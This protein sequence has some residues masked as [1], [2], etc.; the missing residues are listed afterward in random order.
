METV[1]RLI[2]LS[3]SPLIDFVIKGTLVYLAIMWFAMVIW[4]ARDIVNR[5]N[6]VVFQ[7]AMILLNL[8]LP[9]FGLLLYLIIRPSRTLLEKYYE[10]LEYGFLTEHAH[11]E[12]TCPR[13]DENISAD[14]LYCPSCSEKVKSS[15]SSCHH[16]YLNSYVVCPYCGKK[17]KKQQSLK[18]TKKK[19]HAKKQLSTAATAE[20]K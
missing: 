4:V 5:S 20:K 16:V 10:E 3:E 2:A 13:C 6:N 9:V 18:K 14:F 1:E 11:Q 7:S 19:K 12:E 8:I 15:C 17:G